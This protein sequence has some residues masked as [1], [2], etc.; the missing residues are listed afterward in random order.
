MPTSTAT[1]LP[2]GPQLALD[3]RR[4]LDELN[5]TS[6][7]AGELVCNVEDAYGLEF[8]ATDGQRPTE[9]EQ[10]KA[11]AAMPAVLERLAKLENQL[12]K[13]LWSLAKARR[14]LNRIVRAGQGNLPR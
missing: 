2:D 14:G 3:L 13:Q 8:P 5:S 11:R 4:A 10:A 9:A 7:D 12:R 1:S 6:E